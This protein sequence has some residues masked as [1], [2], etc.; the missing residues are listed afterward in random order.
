MNT[1]SSKQNFYEIDNAEEFDFD[2]LEASLEAKLESDLA[3]YEIL[4]VE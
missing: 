3:D 2:E 4:D 1:E